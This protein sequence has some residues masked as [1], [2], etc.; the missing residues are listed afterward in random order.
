MDNVI[1]GQ[2]NLE[3]KV[4]K[5]LEHYDII[6][7][8]LRFAA[9]GFLN[10]AINFLV[11]NGI[12]KAMGISEGIPLGAVEAV[13][14][15]FA[16]IQ[17]YLWNRVWTF[18]GE[19]GV[20]IWKNLVRLI[21][22]GALGVISII[23]VLVGSRLSAQPIFFFGILLVFLIC[24]FVLWRAFGFDTSTTGHTSNSFLAFFI[25]TLVGW[26][27]NVGLVTIVSLHLH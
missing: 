2:T 14:F 15:I 20:S 25:V 13:A 8:F 18:G 7:Q 27:I 4:T 23:L 5:F 1:E 9:I 6:Y 26:G 10:V 11:L 21:L 3:T 24:Q 16:L 12:S 17:S 19:Q 22:V